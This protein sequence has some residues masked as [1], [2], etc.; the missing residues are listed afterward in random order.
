MTKEA[1]EKARRDMLARREEV[2]TKHIDHLETEA[3]VRARLGGICRQTILDM[4]KAGRFPQPIRIGIRKYWRSS[5]T[6]HWL[7]TQQPITNDSAP[8]N[9]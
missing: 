7:L 9:P 4:V 2:K 6:S 1:H 8:G 5:V 3:E